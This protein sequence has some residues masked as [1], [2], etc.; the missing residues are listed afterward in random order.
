MAEPLISVNFGP[1]PC[2]PLYQRLITCTKT[3]VLSDRMCRAEY[4][5]W[6][7]CKTHNKHRAF[8]QFIGQELQKTRIYSLPVY[9][10]AT[11]TFKDGP[12]PVGLD[13][14]FSK[15]PKE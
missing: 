9:D 1:H 14:Y 12:L 13:G 5:D 8:T 11:D 15:D 10:V 3:E 6:E 2:Y 4:L 7:E